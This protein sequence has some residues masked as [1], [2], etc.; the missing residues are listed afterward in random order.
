MLDRLYVLEIYPE[1]ISDG[2]GLRYSIHLAGCSHRCPGCHN[3]ESWDPAAGDPL[4]EEFLNH[5]C[6][7]IND[8]PLLDGITLSGG[9]PFHR[10]G[11]LLE[12]LRT[13]KERTGQNI[14]CYTG[15]A[16]GVPDRPRPPRLP[17]L[18]RHAG[19]RPLRSSAARPRPLVPRE[20]QPAHPA[21][22]G[23]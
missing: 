18:D 23:A 5:I 10:P 21:P 20:L 14:W 8:N 13:L 7:N 15:Y 6:N 19:R 17:A 4:T 16:R 12:L 9:D 2:Y 3:P 22:E 11:L 1:T